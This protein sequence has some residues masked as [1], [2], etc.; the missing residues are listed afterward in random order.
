VRVRPL[1]TAAVLL[2]GGAG[3]ETLD[4]MV[5]EVTRHIFDGDQL[6]GGCLG[7]HIASII[8][9]AKAE[10]V[11]RF[12]DT[13]PGSDVMGGGWLHR[14]QHG[15][16]LAALAQIGQEHGYQL[17]SDFV[18]HQEATRDGRYFNITQRWV[19]SFA[20][21]WAMVRGRVV[22]EL[23][24]TSSAAALK[25]SGGLIVECDVRGVARPGRSREAARHRAPISSSTTPLPRTRGSRSRGGVEGSLRLR[26]KGRARTPTAA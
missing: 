9:P 1:L 4:R 8:G 11:N 15:H 17:V 20:E 24:T 7:D 26:W 6:V 19:S 18:G 21:M 22:E 3:L 16:D 14:I 5:S 25:L 12:M 23:L 2:S 13:V 10:A